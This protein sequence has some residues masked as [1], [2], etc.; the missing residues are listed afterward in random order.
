[1]HFIQERAFWSITP[2]TVLAP[3]RYLPVAHRVPF[4]GA[5]PQQRD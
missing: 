2:G 3:L 1:L 5:Q 4:W